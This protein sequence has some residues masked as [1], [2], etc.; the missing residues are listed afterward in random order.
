MSGDDVNKAGL[1]KGVDGNHNWLGCWV[2]V[3]HTGSVSAL[4]IMCWEHG[5]GR[6]M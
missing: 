5:G 4:G 6:I 3:P 2:D 1:R